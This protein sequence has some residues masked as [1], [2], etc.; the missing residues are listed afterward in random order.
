MVIFLQRRIQLLQARV[1]KLWTY[2]RLSDPSRVSPMNPEIK[3]LEKRVRSLTT[4]T[5]KKI[6]PVCLALPF[7]STHPLPM[8]LN[9]TTR[10]NSLYFCLLF[11]LLSC[12]IILY[13]YLA[14][15]SSVPDFTSSSSQRRL[16]KRWT[17][18]F[19]PPKPPRLP[20]VKDKEKE[21]F[22]LKEQGPHSLFRRLL[23]QTKMEEGKESTRKRSL[24]RVLLRRHPRSS[25]IL[26]SHLSLSLFDL[27]DSDP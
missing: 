14:P 24:P 12:S 22:L 16:V 20:R 25:H 7:D 27:L 10:R 18:F 3:D 4:L 26:Q 2:S 15:G 5:P 21:K 19:W 17:R 23:W 9:F 11:Y 8:V 13:V 1:S 6:V